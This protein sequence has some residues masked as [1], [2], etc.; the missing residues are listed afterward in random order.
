MI[1]IIIITNIY[2]TKSAL[3]ELINCSTNNLNN[4]FSLNE[5]KTSYIEY[6]KVGLSQDN[7][8][9]NL[10]NNSKINMNFYYTIPNEKF[11][12]NNQVKAGLFNPSF[13]DCAKYGIQG[14]MMY[15]YVPD[16]N[17]NKWYQYFQTN[18][19]N[20]VLKDESLR[21]VTTKLNVVKEQDPILGFQQPQT[22][23]VVPGMIETKK[24]NI[25]ANLTNNS[26]K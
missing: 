8:K 17:L 15:L 23:S 12:N 13:Q 26:F 24:S 7:D 11:K 20:P 19:M 1:K 6:N 10:L 3:D 22:Y 25:S 5:Y 2:P 21:L 4:Y 16:D 18:N 14:A 9:T